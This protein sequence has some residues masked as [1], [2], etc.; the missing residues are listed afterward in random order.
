MFF[1]VLLQTVVLLFQP[2]APLRGQTT[3]TVSGKAMDAAHPALLLEQV[4]VINLNT[5]QGVFG[6]ADNSFSVQIS[7]D[8]TLIITAMGYRSDKIC[9]RDSALKAHYHI[10]VPLRKLSINLE[11]ATVFVPRDLNRIEQDIKKLGYNARDYRLSGVDA[12]Q[13]PVTALYQEFS[14]KERSKRKVAELMNEDRRRELLREVLA[15]YARA[16]LI[17]LRYNEYNAFIDYLAL[18]EFMLQAFTQYEL[19][20]YIKKKYYSYMER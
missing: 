15:N 1:Y 2:A 6:A 19:A 4:M 16:G 13:S 10:I 14:R 12:W 18:N 20:F 7:K 11:E 5:Q 9:F 3:I 17:K 8:D